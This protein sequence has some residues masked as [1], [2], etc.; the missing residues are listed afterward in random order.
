MTRTRII[1]AR[2]PGMAID[3]TVVHKGRDILWCGATRR[4]LTAC[5]RRLADWRDSQHP[6]PID[7]AHEDACARAAGVDSLSPWRD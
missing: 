7:L 3:G 4:V 6:D 5:P 1:A 2:Y